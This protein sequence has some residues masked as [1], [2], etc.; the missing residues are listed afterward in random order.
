MAST[1]SGRSAT[2][3]VLSGLVLALTG[4]L[5]TSFAVAS[6][7]AATHISVTAA[8]RMV[9][10]GDETVKELLTIQLDAIDKKLDQ[11]IAAQGQSP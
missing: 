7:R 3:Y 11:L 2:T 5:I 8:Q 10:R 6:N 4:A 1:N 9:D